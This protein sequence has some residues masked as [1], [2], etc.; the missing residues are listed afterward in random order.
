MDKITIESPNWWLISF[1]A[2]EGY[3][4][5]LANID[6]VEWLMIPENRDRVILWSSPVTKAQAERLSAGRE[7]NEGNDGKFDP[8]SLLF[9]L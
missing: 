6:P 7:W 9:P 2:R 8:R 1:K 4:T 3:G 5:A